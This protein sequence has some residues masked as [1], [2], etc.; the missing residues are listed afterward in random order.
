MASAAEENNP[1][2]MQPAKA[3]PKI[4]G[5]HYWVI[6]LVKVKVKSK[7]ALMKWQPDER[8]SCYVIIKVYILSPFL[9][10]NIQV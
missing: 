1:W 8:L 2:K 3:C 7:L 10:K 4:I 6:I 5:S 9:K